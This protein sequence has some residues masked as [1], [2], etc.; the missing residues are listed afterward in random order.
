MTL[1]T[2]TVLGCALMLTY[3]SLRA[4]V[5]LLTIF[6]SMQGEVQISSHLIQY[7][8]LPLVS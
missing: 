6:T 3:V 2:A 8:S 1:I 5:V 7:K 4:E